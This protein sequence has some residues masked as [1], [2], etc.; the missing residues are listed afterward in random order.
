MSIALLTAWAFQKRSR[1]QQLTLCRSLHAE[2]LQAIASERLAQGPYMAARAGFEPTTLRSNGVV[3][4]NAPS[5]PTLTHKYIHPY[6]SRRKHTCTHL[7]P[8]AANIQAHV[9]T[10]AHAIKRVQTCPQYMHIIYEYIQR[11]QLHGCDGNEMA[12]EWT[13]GVGRR[14]FR[15]ERRRI[16]LVLVVSTAFS[17]PPTNPTWNISKNSETWRSSSMIAMR[18]IARQKRDDFLFNVGLYAEVW[19]GGYWKPMT[20]CIRKESRQKARFVPWLLSKGPLCHCP[21]ITI[22]SN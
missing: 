15:E 10:Y 16:M 4:T 1:P 17:L 3:S 7:Q 19:H 12:F 18:Q 22:K 11:W 5:C 21:R 13:V 20:G 14:I 6:K 9:P 8:D 2:E